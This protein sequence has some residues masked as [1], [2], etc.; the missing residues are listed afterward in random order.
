MK[1]SI[2]L[3]LII[4][5]AILLIGVGIVG[6][7]RLANHS[8]SSSTKPSTIPISI[9]QNLSFPIYVPNTSSE[10]NIDGSG[11]SYDQQS[12]VLSLTLTQTNGAQI[13]LTQQSTPQVFND[14]PQQYPKLLATMN[15]YS[16]IQTSFGTVGL[17]HPKELNGN[18]TAISNKAGTLLFAKPNRDLPDDEWKAFFNDL[19]LL[20]Q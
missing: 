12:G 16:E 19:R 18:Q 3:V 1:R 15:Q 5:A 20:K 11:T 9:T 2:R 4:I 10:W 8:K 6:G 17:T 13:I 14:V 7:L